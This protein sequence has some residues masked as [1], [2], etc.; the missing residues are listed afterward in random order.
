MIRDLLGWPNGHRSANHWPIVEKDTAN[1]LS[2]VTYFKSKF[3]LIIIYA[4]PYTNSIALDL[5]QSNKLLGGRRLPRQQRVD[6][7]RILS[8]SRDRQ[9]PPCARNAGKHGIKNCRLNLETLNRISQTSQKQYLQFAN[10]IQPVFLPIYF[11]IR[12]SIDIL[13]RKTWN[14]NVHYVVF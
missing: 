13:W 3:H 11:D 8:R 7:L 5:I 9:R 1:I 14:P 12:R 10:Y 4:T 2:F 6:D